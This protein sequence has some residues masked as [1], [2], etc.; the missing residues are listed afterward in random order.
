MSTTRVLS[1]DTAPASGEARGV[2]KL[3]VVTFGCQMN[4][5][6]SLLAEGRFRREGW[7][8]TSSMEEA[9]LVL[10]NTCSVREHAEDRTWSWVGELKS[11]KQRRPELVVGVMGCMAQRV[12]D[13]IFAR[14]GHVDIVAGTRQFARLPR[15]VDEVRRARA[16]G[17]RR[18][19][20]VLALGMEDALAVDR[21]DEPWDGELHAY[22]TVMRGCGLNC[23][24]CIVPSV[25][26]RV[27]S[28]PIEHLVREA[29]GFVAKGVRVIT[30]LGQTV[31]SYGEDC[32]APG[33]GEPVLRG[34]QGRPSLADLLYALQEIEGLARI[35]LITL[36][37]SYVTPALAQAI[38]ECGKVERFLPLPAQS[39]S[40]RILRAMKRGYNAELYRKRTEMLRSAVP[41]IELGSDWIV[42]FPSETDAE[43]D[44]SERFLAEQAFAVNYIFKYSPRPGTAA[45]ALADDVPE[46]E[47]KR[48]NQR[49]LELGAKAGLA[50]NS[51]HVGQLRRTFVEQV[52]EKRDGE[53]SGRTQHGILVSFA[54]ASEL[55]GREVDVRIEGASAY[56]LLGALA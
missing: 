4:K 40:D 47:K 15:L 3:H 36:H 37:P 21:G 46:E 45:E 53:V 25:R 52:S 35:R 17:E 55:V 23:T 8:L 51:A 1:A 48:R 5:Y 18:K 12:G 38:A 42:G 34:R 31:N 22:L 30:L 19:A 24:Y 29:R 41:D 6:D 33:P 50:R 54:G 56:G 7:A 43:H 11:V 39:G 20:R 27:L 32:P 9:D 2:P 49:L 28:Y 10:F 13:G 16:S 14:A 44:E 26:G